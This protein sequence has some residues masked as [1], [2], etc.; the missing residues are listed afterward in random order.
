[1][2]QIL[3]AVFKPLLKAVEKSKKLATKPTK[4]ASIAAIPELP[5]GKSML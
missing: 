3:S 4:H 2:I 5:E 1:L